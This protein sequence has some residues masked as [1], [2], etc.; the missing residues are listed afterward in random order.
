[1]DSLH[2]DS[3]QWRERR[4]TFPDFMD[5]IPQDSTKIFRESIKI[6]SDSLEA[7][8]EYGAVDTQ[9]VDLKENKV[10]LFGGAYV[11][12]TNL[13]LTA[14][15]IIFD[16]DSDI[17][18]AESIEIDG[19]EV[20]KPTF[21]DG[22][23]EFTYDKLKYNFKTKKGIIYQAV[24]QQGEMFLHGV[25]TKFISKES[26]TLQTEDHI[27]N[28]DALITTCD[29]DHP[30]FGIR[31]SK[32][33]LIPDRLAIIGPARL[34]LAGVPTPLWLPF[35]FFPIIKGESSG[36]IFPDDYEY[37]QQN[38]FGL[39][40][41]GYYFPINDYIDATVTADLYT[42]G[43]WGLQLGT[44]YNKR[45][46]YSGDVQ[47]A[48]SD[49]RTENAL[50]EITS[51]K[52]YS[53]QLRHNQAAKA[54]PYRKIQG[55][56]SIQTN[57]YRQDNF[58]TAQNVLENTYRSNFYYNHSLPGSPF[59]IGVGF[60]HDQNTRTGVVNVTFPDIVLNMNTIQPFK[61]KAQTGSGEKWYEK[62]TLKYDGGF[63]NYVR[64]SDTTLFTQ[65]VIDDF[66][67]G[68]NHKVSSNASF[69]M[70]KYFN[71]SPNISY[72]EKWFF[73]TEEKIL[74]L[75]GTLDS[76]NV[77][78]TSEGDT[79]WEYNTIYNIE[80]QLNTGFERYNDLNM[81][82]NIS[83]Q[84]FG[85]QRFRRGPI[86]GLRHIMKP[87]IGF[88]YSPDT[89]D[90]YEQ[91]V[92]DSPDV[93]LR[94][95]IIYNPFVNSSLG[96]TSLHRKRMAITYGINNIFEGKYFSRKDSTEK[97]FKIFDNINVNG[98]YNFAAD[99]LKWSLINVSGNARYFKGIT[100]VSLS[101]VFDPNILDENDRRTNVSVWDKKKRIADFRRFNA[102]IGTRFK[103]KQIR[104][105][106]FGK[107]EEKDD[108]KKKTP[109]NSS[110]LEL[111]DN[112]NIGHSLRM[113]AD[114]TDT[115]DTFYIQTNAL[116]IS[117]RINLTDNWNINVQNITYD[118]KNRSF[119]YPSF[120]FS[121]DLHCWQ[122]DFG[123]FPQRGVY[124]FN[125]AVKSTT[126]DF[127]KYNYGRGN[128]DGLNNQFF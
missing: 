52:A 6:S 46:S 40:R 125:I 105:L 119:V 16:L 128:V 77:D 17:A 96:G 49:R 2:L 99:S 95:S 50:G 78:I 86:R 87:T 34:E 27:Y 112:F 74:D 13:K 47:L 38:G 44:K 35:G 100:T 60:K 56:I 42:R 19:E 121:R 62:F 59:K 65:Q 81:G 108:S 91:L 106:I 98:N 58:N 72:D 4:D 102:N 85:T 127:L 122:M 84:I 11:N 67:Y 68:F 118:L 109:E 30:H 107:G 57:D 26:D 103:F 93:L 8:I 89:K 36:I 101:A 18:I 22:N 124:T 51:K 83:T 21:N 24:T 94:D 73:Q 1:M 28:K 12:Y 115:R 90:R 23:Q 7:T 70:A 82:V 92:Y 55:S 66:Q 54:H 97:K 10:H 5:S 75:N 76:T 14:G 88:N 41:F 126:L 116:T 25:K 33:K 48:F 61:R 79:I 32:L 39:R 117:G 64:T 113:V 120:S 110:F 37:S 111:F 15:Y 69:R 71:V 20:E 29:A 45:Y 3:T 114:H 53:I 123:W 63:K 80:D 31:T 43:T 104:E 9:W